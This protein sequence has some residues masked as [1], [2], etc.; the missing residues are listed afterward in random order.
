MI[1]RYRDGRTDQVEPVTA[2]ALSAQGV[3]HQRSTSSRKRDQRMP[4]APL[5]LVVVDHAARRVVGVRIGER[6]HGA[7]VRVK[8]PVRVGLSDLFRDGEHVSRA[9]PAGR[10]S[11]AG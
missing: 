3:V 1:A 10:R 4:G 7:A 11:R 5:R 6:M 8:L 9:A 2:P